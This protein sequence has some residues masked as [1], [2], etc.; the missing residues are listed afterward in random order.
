MPSPSLLLTGPVLGSVCVLV[1]SQEG[2]EGWEGGGFDVVVV[3][4][5]DGD[6]E[7]GRQ[8]R[9]GRKKT[10]LIQ[11]RVRAVIS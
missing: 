11:S 10:K 6:D 8:E 9:A 3:V 4:D 5:G 7:G 2:R 1:W